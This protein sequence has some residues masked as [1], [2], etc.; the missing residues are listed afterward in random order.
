MRSITLHE[1]ILFVHLLVQINARI[2]GIPFVLGLQLARNSIEIYYLVEF[3]I[4]RET[5]SQID[6]MYTLQRLQQ[7]LL[8]R[9]LLS[10]SFF[11]RPPIDWNN[12][13]ILGAAVPPLC[14]HIQS[15]HPSVCPVSTNQSHV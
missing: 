8:R 9:R 7:L 5:I 15:I 10:F 1:F 12:Y 3:L 14:S 6:I 2:A 13:T 4:N 11:S